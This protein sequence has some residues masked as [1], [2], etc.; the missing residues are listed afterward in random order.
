MTNTLLIKRS[1]TANAIP[2]AGQLEYGELAINYR[3][4]N[5]FYKNNGNQVIVIAS[6]QVLS[7]SGNVTGGNINTSGQVSA[8]SAIIGNVLI[9][10]DIITPISYDSYGVADTGTLTVNGNL[11]VIGNVTGNYFI[12]NGS[13]LT[14]IVATEIGTLTSLSVIGNTTTGNLLTGGLISAAGNVTAGNIITSGA[15]G[16]ITGANVI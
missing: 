8:T 3:D 14:G 9:T 12:G 1:S 10:D 13:Q 2:T 4:G 6:N 7:V 11:D 16:N 5:L 15:S